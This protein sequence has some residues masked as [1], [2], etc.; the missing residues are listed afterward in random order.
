MTTLRISRKST[1]FVN[2]K[3]LLD[4]LK[5]QDNICTATKEGE[6]STKVDDANVFNRYE[7]DTLDS[8]SEVEEMEND[9]V[10]N[11]DDK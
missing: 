9:Y 3:C 10:S 5:D 2:D 1:R 11:V 4:S 7:T 6:P 8:E